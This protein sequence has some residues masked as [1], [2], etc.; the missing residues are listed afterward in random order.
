MML[1]LLLNLWLT[2][3]AQASVEWKVKLEGTVIAANS[4]VI[5]IR[6]PQNQILNLV[7]HSVPEGFD[8]TPGKTIRWI[9]PEIKVR[10]PSGE[11][12]SPARK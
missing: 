2:T 9:A 5:Q 12:S 7:R 10:Q 11:T 8:L 6:T 3:P 1:A 4:R